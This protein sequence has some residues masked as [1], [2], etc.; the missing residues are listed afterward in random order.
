MQDPLFSPIQD[1]Y[2]VSSDLGEQ[3]GGKNRE[4][5]AEWVGNRGHAILLL[6]SSLKTIKSFFSWA[7]W[8]M[9]TIPVT[10][11]PKAGLQQ[12]PGQHSESQKKQGVGV[13]CRG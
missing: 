10:Q 6:R 2:L 4:D 7:Y 8:H 13:G 11:E 3:K 1:P 5:K 12:Q 9:P